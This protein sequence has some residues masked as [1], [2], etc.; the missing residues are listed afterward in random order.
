MSPRAMAPRP[1]SPVS[2]RIRSSVLV[3]SLAALLFV[4]LAAS[5]DVAQAGKPRAAAKSRV[6]ARTTKAVTVLPR[7]A[8]SKADTA[9]ALTLLETTDIHGALLDGAKDRNGA[10]WGS[11]AVLAAWERK[12]I[13]QAG[14]I[15]VLV[16]GGDMFQGSPISTVLRGRSVMDFMNAAHYDAAAC[17]NHEFD[18]TVD[19]L[20][21]RIRQANFPVLACNIFEKATN[22]QPDWIAPY[23]LV[24]RGR[25]TVGIVGAATPDTPLVTV[26]KN[27]SALRFDDPVA[28]INAY[29]DTCRARGADVVIALLH[30][31]GESIRD[32]SAP[33]GPIY[34][35]APQLRVDALFGGHTHQFVTTTIAGKPVMIAG[36]HGRAVA[37]VGL[38]INRVAHSVLVTKQILHRTYA[39]S[40]Q[41]SPTD[42]VKTIVDR[43]NAK[44]APIMARTLG[45]ASGAYLREQPA[46]GNFVADVMK[47]A[48]GVQIAFTNSGGLRADL[49][50]GTVTLGEIYEIMPFDNALVTCTLTGAQVKHV[51]E[52]QP[53]KIFFSGMRAT[54]DGARPDG[55]HA[56]QLVLDNGTPIDSAATYTV[57]TND[58]MWQGGDGFKTFADGGNVVQTGKLIR[59]A[60]VDFV[61][62][63]GKSHAP[64]APDAS[65][66]YA[67]RPGRAAR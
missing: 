5:R 37:E 29:A 4:G 20:V 2:S 49:D 8:V 17:G 64:I 47:S 10:A 39:D 7:L 61:D 66:R 57:V 33:K 45:V 46:M 58:F 59:D 12:L 53:T 16:D 67:G 13:D 15:A 27:V 41:V 36:S 63:A 11:A 32:G 3:A 24:R 48:A 23:T 44:V 34:D 43:Y 35:M 60:M 1:A 9:L 31:G 30:I 52:E 54:Y 22:K 42:K 40:V 18:W 6:A 21:A 14:G 28:L 51:L 65:N 26:P 62:A 38:K 55:D 56:T 25:V 50:S 19:T